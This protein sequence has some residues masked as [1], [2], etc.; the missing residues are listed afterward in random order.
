MFYDKSDDKSDG[1]RGG[2]KDD[3]G[4]EKIWKSVRLAAE[5]EMTGFEDMFVDMGEVELDDY[6][7][8]EHL[9]WPGHS[10]SATGISKGGTS[11][12][13]D[14]ERPIIESVWEFAEVVSGIDCALWRKDEFGDWIYRMDYGKRQSKFGWEIFDPGI[15][16]HNQ[17]VYAMRPMQWNNYV[18]QF[19]SS[20]E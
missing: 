18:D 3:R 2:K 14:Y 12:T 9:F 17:G 13:R 11:F 7:G 8:D 10:E 20:G 19:S 1:K 5:A 6:P 4:D 16:R 15:G